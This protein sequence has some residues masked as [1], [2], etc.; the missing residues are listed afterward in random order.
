[1]NKGRTAK[2]RY[3][4]RHLAQII[5][6]NDKREVYLQHRDS[7]APTYPNA[8]GLFAGGI[9]PGE[10]ARGA[11]IR[12][13]GEETSYRLKRPRLLDK[14]KYSDGKYRG[15]S[16][17]YI[18]K[19]DGAAKLECHEGKAGLWLSRE[20]VEKAKKVID[21]DK[22]ILD[23]FFKTIKRQLLRPSGE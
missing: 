15:L 14:R 20:R 17:V 2:T 22:R 5:L 10:T 23:K 1:M 12:E 3:P 16:Y 7:K 8:I 19:Y 11:V 9:E 6:Y 4:V 21:L 18:E 13:C